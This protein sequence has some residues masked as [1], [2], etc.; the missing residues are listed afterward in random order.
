MAIR[1]EVA[2]SALPCGDS[3][4]L[5]LMYAVLLLGR[6]ST[7]P[8]WP[9]WSAE[10]KSRCRWSPLITFLPQ[11]RQRT[12]PSSPLFELSLNAW[13]DVRPVSHV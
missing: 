13:A 10:G 5:F 3:S 6:T 11:S 8:G 7:T 9:G 1:S 4:N 12:P 2:P